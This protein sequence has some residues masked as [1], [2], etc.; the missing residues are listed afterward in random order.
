[1][2]DQFVFRCVWKADDARSEGDAIAAWQSAGDKLGILTDEQRAKLLC[3]VGYDG[4]RL[5]ATLTCQIRYFPRVRENMAFVQVFVAP[6]Y[7]QRGVVTRLMLGAYAAMSRYAL[8]H[9][10]LRI[11]GIAVRSVVQGMT[12]KPVGASGTVLIGYDEES[13]SIRIRWFDHF[14]IDEKAARARAPQKPLRQ[15][16]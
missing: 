8:E 1:V 13:H 2:I 4:S 14:K 3:I 10:A 15:A 11:G 12:D 6:D 5:F 7:R 9:P 16:N